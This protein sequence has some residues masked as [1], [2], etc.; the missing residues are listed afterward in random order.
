MNKDKLTFGDLERGDKFIA[1]PTPGDNSGH[2]GYKGGYVLFFKWPLI[3]G[4]FCGKN[5]SHGTFSD[6][7]D[8][9]EVI[10]II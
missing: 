3:E 2:G 6:F 7:P 1:F 9:M 4:G 5:F 8:S 10:K